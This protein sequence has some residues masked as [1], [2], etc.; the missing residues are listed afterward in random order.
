MTSV[1]QLPV[2]SLGVCAIDYEIHLEFLNLI[3]SD[4]TAICQ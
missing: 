4:H 3:R 2:M 1:E